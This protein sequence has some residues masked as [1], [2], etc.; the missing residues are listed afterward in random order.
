MVKYSRDQSTEAPRRFIWSVMAE[1]YCCFQAQTRSVKA[2][3][4]KSVRGLAFGGELA[5][6]HH[7]RG[8][9]GV[10]GAGNP[11]GGVAGHAM[12]AREDV[13]LGLVEHVAHVQAAGDVGR[14][15][16]LDEGLD[17]ACV[18]GVGTE[19]IFSSTQNLDHF[20]SISEGSY[21]LG[22]S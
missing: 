2:S 7:L 19:K 14:R 4:P 15:Q 9:A 12:P 1:P 11:D 3:R 8:D 6:D 20:S 17:A 5:L 18:G 10:V 13:H 21:A 22:S 16:Q